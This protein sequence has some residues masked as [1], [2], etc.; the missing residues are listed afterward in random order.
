MHTQYANR[1]VY[2]KRW[3]ICDGWDDNEWSVTSQAIWLTELIMAKHGP[4]ATHV[5]Y[6]ARI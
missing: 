6:V 4:A 3:I 2:T 1:N 5:I